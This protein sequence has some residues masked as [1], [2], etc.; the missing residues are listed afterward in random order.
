MTK[1]IIL[2]AVILICIMILFYGVKRGLGAQDG[3]DDESIRQFRV[4][5]EKTLAEGYDIVLC[6]LTGRRV[7][8][9]VGNALQLAMIREFEVVVSIKDEF[10]CGSIISEWS[11]SD[12]LY[13]ESVNC[14]LKPVDNREIHFRMA[15]HDDMVC[16]KEPA[17]HAFAEGN[18]FCREYHMTEW[19]LPL[20]HAVAPDSPDFRA[21]RAE[22]DSLKIEYGG[23]GEKGRP[24]EK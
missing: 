11:T 19:L 10:V 8:F 4:E 18:E 7:F 20:W 17:G 21:L 12:M 9:R 6:R 14:N 2:I 15:K 13:H 23:K 5:A 16:T 22:F 1:R 3:T 24:P